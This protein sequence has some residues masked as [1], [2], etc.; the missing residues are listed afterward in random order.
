[1]KRLRGIPSI[2]LLLSLILA[3]FLPNARVSAAETTEYVHARPSVNGNLSVDGVKSYMWCKL[4]PDINVVAVSAIL[5]THKSE[6]CMSI[7]DGDRLMS[8]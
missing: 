5:D 7:T 6:R 8:S 1:M 3:C 4:I 2:I